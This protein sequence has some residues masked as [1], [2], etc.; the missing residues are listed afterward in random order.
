MD[1]QR[2]LRDLVRTPP[3]FSGVDGL[4]ET[5]YNKSLREVPYV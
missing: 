4:W 3:V 2:V 1:L 5:R